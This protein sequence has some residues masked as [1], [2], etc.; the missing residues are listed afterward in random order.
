M[1]SKK[2][3]IEAIEHY[4]NAPVTIDTCEKLAAL[5][6]VKDR[7]YG[8]DHIENGRDYHEKMSR[9]SGAQAPEYREEKAKIQVP[10]ATSEFLRSVDGMDAKAF[11]KVMDELVET[12]KII[13]PRLYDGFMR[14]LND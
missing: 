14:K 1:I 9:Y 12:V 4:K 8:E 7:L 2:E 11:W 10:D 3:L 5:Y 13:N 6:T